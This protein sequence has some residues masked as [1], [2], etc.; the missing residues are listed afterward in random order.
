MSP[1]PTRPYN[2]LPRLPP[3]IDLETKAVMRRCVAARAA[4]AELRLAGQ[5]IP[6]QSVLI[7][8]I[9]LLEAK[10][11]SEIENIVTTNDVLFRE[12][13]SAEE[14][15]DPAAKEALRYRSALTGGYQALKARPLTTR[16]AT[17]ICGAIKGVEME[18][19]RTPGT[20]VKNSFTGEII[21]TPPEG[22][23]LLR[24]LLADWERY[25]HEESEVDP[26]IRM[27]V[28]HYQFEAIHPF[29]DGNGRTGR[30]LNILI[31]IQAGLLEIP[32]LYLSRHILRTRGQYYTLLQGVTLRGE[33]EPWVLY[34]LTAAETTAKWTNARIRAIRELMEH[35]AAHIRIEAPGIYSREL[36]DTIFAQP[37]ARIGHL[38][39]AGIA[40]RVSASRYLKQLAAS[41]ILKEEKIG[42]DKVFIHTKYMELLAGNGHEFAPYVRS[43]EW[44]YRSR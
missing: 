24:N 25:L 21:Y 22:E 41:G 9:P 11:S 32:T 15:D 1:D 42:R 38:I 2:G 43:L 35:T 17:D 13:G 39:E 28:L 3:D 18:V 16:T 23:P 20:Q 44:L 36:V 7:N 40:K 8:T 10:D 26:L 33:W 6:D 5:L 31:L 37:Y 14:T 19:R 30:I 34:M 27:A 12:A 29:I 4:I